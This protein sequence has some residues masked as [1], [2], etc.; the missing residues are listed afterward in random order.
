VLLLF[1][2]GLSPT[3]VEILLLLFVLDK[4]SGKETSETSELLFG[5]LAKVLSLLVT[6][7]SWSWRVCKLLLGTLGL[8]RI[9]ALD[10]SWAKGED[11]GRYSQE[12]ELVSFW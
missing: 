3:V 1:K 12:V 4:V 7:L 6:W 8:T 11:S 9:T 10:G 5:L 2:L